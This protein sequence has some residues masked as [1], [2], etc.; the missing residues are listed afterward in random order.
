MPAILH[1]AHPLNSNVHLS[2][3]YT[4]LDYARALRSHYAT[5][6]R[7]RRDIVVIV[8]LA[9]IGIYLWQLPDFH[10]LGVAAV[11]GSVGIAAM[12]LAAFVVV[13]PLAFRRQLKF[14]DE[15][16]LTF[17]AAGIHFRTAHI[18]S[19]LEWMLYSR[20]S[21]DRH[22]YL[23]YYGTTQFTIIPKRVF[24]SADERQAFE[25]LLAQHVAQID[26]RG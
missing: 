14:R 25:Q 9:G 21:I 12:I 24:Q 20:A 26:R 3:R 7:V 11:V 5:H 17:S 2:F 23:L 8:V 6:L 19:Q 16:S 13:P 15:Y 1:R 4:E 10:S 22:S 18:D